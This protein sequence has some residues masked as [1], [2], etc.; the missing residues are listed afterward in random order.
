MRGLGLGEGSNAEVVI[1]AS[2][3]RHLSH[4]AE[5]C[6]ECRFATNDLL[7]AHFVRMPPVPSADLVVRRSFYAVTAGY[8]DRDFG[9][10]D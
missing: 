5:N 10:R 8:R 7:L 2:T 9:E 1:R 4:L 6:A 3:I